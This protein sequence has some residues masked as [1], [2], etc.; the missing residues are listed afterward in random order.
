MFV[1][2]PELSSFQW[3][4]VASELPGFLLA[5]TS[6]YVGH[7]YSRNVTATSGTDGA[8]GG[9]EGL[10]STVDPEVAPAGPARAA[11]QKTTTAMTLKAV[12]PR[13]RM[14]VRKTTFLDLVVPCLGRPR[15]SR[16]SSVAL[17]R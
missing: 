13:V 10:E 6:P 8:P 16:A 15:S 5:G 7:E 12:R 4:P 3:P 14:E 1:W 2:T 17:R 9:I 11:S